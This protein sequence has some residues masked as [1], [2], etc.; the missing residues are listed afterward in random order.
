[1]KEETVSVAPPGPPEVTLI[2]ISASFN[3]KMMR[4]TMAV[5]L[6]GSISGKV[7][8]QNDCQRL[9]PSTFAA[10]ESSLG[11]ACNPA[12]N[13]I[14]MKGIQTQASINEMLILAIQGVVKKAGLSQPR[15]RAKVAI[16]P[17]RYSIRDFPIIQ[18]TATGL[19]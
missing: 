16:G 17:K 10:S 14:M 1:M 2:T 4:S 5:A 11:R 9:A 7:I 12:S 13:M 19:S 18:L 15:C 8:S 3:W 6:T